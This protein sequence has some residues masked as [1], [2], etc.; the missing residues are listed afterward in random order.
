[1]R[2][3]R[4]VMAIAGVALIACTEITAGN[5]NLA[6]TYTLRTMNGQSLPF[7][8]PGGTTQVI[9]DAISVYEGG[10]WS[11]TGHVRTTPS[12]AAETVSR[13]GPFTSFGTSLSFRVN[14]TGATRVA[15]YSADALTF[16]ED[17]VTSVYKR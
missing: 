1:M 7:T 16:V 14:E 12:G 10:T 13:T 8:A 11:S 6:G 15:V 9:D 3:L 5:P 17:G 4:L 2:I